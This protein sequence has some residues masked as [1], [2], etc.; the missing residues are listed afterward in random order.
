MRELKL[1]E[2]GNSLGVVLTK[3]LLAKLRVGK[4][5]KLFA[6]ETTNGVELSPYNPE[7]ANQLERAAKIMHEDR[8]VLRKLAE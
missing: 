3:D 4:G 8:N 1:T 6:I 7:L 2:I 5:D